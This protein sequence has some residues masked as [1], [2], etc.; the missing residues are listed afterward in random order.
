MNIKHKLNDLKDR[1]E[2][3]CI[4]SDQNDLDSFLTGFLQEIDDEDF[5]LKSINPKGLYDGFVLK[6][7]DSIV[8][9]EAE[10][11]YIKRVKFLSECRPVCHDNIN[12]KG[13]L[14]LD[15]IEYAIEKNKA[16]SIELFHSGYHD[17]IGYP[18]ELEG[19]LCKIHSI[20]DDG[21]YDGYTFIN[22]ASI[23]LLICD[24]VNEQK[25]DILHREYKK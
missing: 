18:E 14:K 9:I 21:E 6:N 7:L 19:D 5:L 24:G 10:S 20:T 11:A 17:V 13:N 23:T 4:Y 12:I 16:V 15:L 22:I 8:K 1:H 3:V 2:I 25:L